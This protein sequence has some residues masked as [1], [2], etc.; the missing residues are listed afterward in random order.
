[1]VDL[2]VK[3]T[4]VWYNLDKEER[5][6]MKR[7]IMLVALLLSM[8]VLIACAGPSPRP[9]LVQDDKQIKEAK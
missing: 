7:L 6:K 1:M 8:S 4:V 9:V 5:E 3:E 2:F